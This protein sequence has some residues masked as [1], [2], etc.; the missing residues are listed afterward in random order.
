M[1][2]ANEVEDEYAIILHDFI[3]DKNKSKKLLS[4]ITYWS[5]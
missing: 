2:K 4:S 1:S 3:K 5:G